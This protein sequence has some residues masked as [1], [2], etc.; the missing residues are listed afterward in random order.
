MSSSSMYTARG[1]VSITPS[2]TVNLAEPARA[3]YVGGAGN[4]SIL[5][6]DGPA[7]TL[8]GVGAGALL[9]ISVARVNVTGTT[10][11]NLVGLL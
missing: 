11:T 3:L 8:M 1:L 2:D 10:A 6:L 7:V 9:P 5:P 4:I